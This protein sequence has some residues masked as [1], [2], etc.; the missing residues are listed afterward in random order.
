MTIDQIFETFGGRKTIWT[1]RGD[2]VSKREV[3]A[4]S[5]ITPRKRIE[6]VKDDTQEREA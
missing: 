2:T 1:K 3:L 6:T 4:I 5:T